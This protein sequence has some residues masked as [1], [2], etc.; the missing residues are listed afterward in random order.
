[1]LTR[2]LPFTGENLL[3]MLHSLHFGAPK[4]IPIFGPDLPQQ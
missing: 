1:M 2:E 3:A 4:D